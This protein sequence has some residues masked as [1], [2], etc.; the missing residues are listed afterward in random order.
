MFGIKILSTDEV[1]MQG[2]ITMFLPVSQDMVSV[3]PEEQGRRIAE[4][5]LACLTSIL[6]NP[7]LYSNGK[8]ALYNLF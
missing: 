7:P 2:T 3:S 8:S 5:E 1:D 6:D 4:Q